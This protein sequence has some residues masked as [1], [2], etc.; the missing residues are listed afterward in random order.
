MTYYLDL[1][2]EN[3]CCAI[4]FA[5]PEHTVVHVGTTIH[6]EEEKYR[7][8]ELALRF[9]EECDFHFFFR[10]DELPELYTVPKTEVGGCDSRGGLF[11]GS[12]DF[13]IRD[14]DPMY[15]IDREGNCFLITQNSSEFLDMGKSWR[16]KMV[17][18]D[19]IEVF[20]SRGEAEKK[21]RIWEWN[22]LLKEG[23]L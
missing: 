19:A 21:Y 1:T 4:L 3:G 2:G 20:A 5:N 10:G 16:E 12:H 15:Y 23:D 14:P 13:T 11:V 6:T 8:H 18:T 9:A 22:E 17:P 7:N